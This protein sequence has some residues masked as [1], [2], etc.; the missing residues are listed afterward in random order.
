MS[1]F[2]HDINEPWKLIPA[3]T[4]QFEAL[5]LEMHLHEYSEEMKL[6]A[7]SG[8]GIQKS[9]IKNGTDTYFSDGGQIVRECC[10]GKDIAQG[11]IIYEGHDH[12]RLDVP[13]GKVPWE[14]THR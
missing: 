12:S 2:P 5:C 13:A 6:P 1:P 14:A 11:W 3:Q 9:I 4:A 8:W 7:A 10:R